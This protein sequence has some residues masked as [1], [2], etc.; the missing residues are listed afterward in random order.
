MPAA[1]KMTAKIAAVT[2]RGRFFRRA[3]MPWRAAP[4]LFDCHCE[5]RSDEAI[6]LKFQMDCRGRLRL[7]RNDRWRPHSCAGLS[8]AWPEARGHGAESLRLQERNADNH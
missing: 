5:E 8:F 7:P 4:G 3:F 2:T 1:L 6:Q